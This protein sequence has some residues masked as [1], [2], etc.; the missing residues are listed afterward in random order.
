VSETFAAALISALFTAIV[1]LLKGLLDDRARAAERAA[2]LIDRHEERQLAEQ[3]AADEAVRRAEERNEARN[4]FEAERDRTRAERE[5]AELYADGKPVAKEL[6]SVL[7]EMQA[8][9]RSDFSR[10]GTYSY[11]P[12]VSARVRNLGLLIPDAV[13]RDIL[14]EGMDVIDHIWVAERVGD[15]D[16]AKEVQRNAM[17]DVMETVAKFIRLEQADETLVLRYRETNMLIAQ[18]HDEYDRASS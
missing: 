1:V 17:K 4:D 8:K 5:K 14:E 10:A 16:N 12:E 13:V 18:S 2:Q 6:L 9:W 7:A 11:Q 15:I 3:N